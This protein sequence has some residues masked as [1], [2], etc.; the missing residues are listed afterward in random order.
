MHRPRRILAGVTLVA[1]SHTAFA[2]DDPAGVVYHHTAVQLG[3]TELTTE[4]LLESRALSLDL[5]LR[6][7]TSSSSP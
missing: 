5:D 2:Q 4:S 6:T 7:L 3:E 1:A